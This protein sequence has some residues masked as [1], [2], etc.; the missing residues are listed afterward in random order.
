MAISLRNSIR[1][2]RHG[3]PRGE[4]IEKVQFLLK[5]EKRYVA[6]HIRYAPL[7]T[8]QRPLFTV[9]DSNPE[10]GLD[11]RIADVLS[12][13]LK[14]LPQLTAGLG[15]KCRQYLVNILNFAVVYDDRS[16]NHLLK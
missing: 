15:R 9:H 3:A 11:L 4:R 16:R 5:T 7:F 13:A 2:R 8:R 14:S 10:L 12:Q 6:D 1:T